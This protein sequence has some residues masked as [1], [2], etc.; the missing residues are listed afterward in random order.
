[1]VLHQVPQRILL[2]PHLLWMEENFDL[3]Q[4][5][6]ILP[7]LLQQLLVHLKHQLLLFVLGLFGIDNMILNVR[8]NSNLEEIIYQFQWSCKIRSSL[9]ASTSNALVSILEQRDQE[10]IH[11]SMYVSSVLW[12]RDPIFGYVIQSKQWMESRQWLIVMQHTMLT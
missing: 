7:P 3:M 2:L 4:L 5:D 11:Q 8:S 9:I 12:R 10:L 1:M 6:N